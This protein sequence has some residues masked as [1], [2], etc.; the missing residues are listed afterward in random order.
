MTHATQLF[1]TSN[2]ITISEYYSC[3]CNSIIAMPI[4]VQQGSIT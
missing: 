3:Y 4:H 2:S 1:K